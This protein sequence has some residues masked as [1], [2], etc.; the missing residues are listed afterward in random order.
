M[1]CMYLRRMYILLLLGWV[2]CACLLGHMVGSVAQVSVFTG[3]PSTA[4]LREQ[5]WELQ[6]YNLFLLSVLPVLLYTFWNFVI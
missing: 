4:L 2:V 3:F 1:F 6:P 5:G